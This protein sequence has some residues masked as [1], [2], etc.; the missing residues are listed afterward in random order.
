LRQRLVPDGKA[1]VTDGGHLILD[2][3]FGRIS[4]PEALA[5]ALLAIPG[6]VQH[7]LFIGL[8][9]RAYVAGDDGVEII[10]A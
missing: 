6:V 5:T 4:R 2:A 8:C 1:Y 3:S 10:D 7:G 9:R